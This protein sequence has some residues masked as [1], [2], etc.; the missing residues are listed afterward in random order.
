MDSI[1]ISKE[2]FSALRGLP[3]IQQLIYLT[4]LK[5]YIDYRTGLVGVKRKVS[6]QSLAEELYI[7]PHQGIK[8]GSPSKDQIRRAIK[9]LERSGV[10]TIR[11]MAWQ[12]I[13]Y[14]PLALADYSILNKAAT[15]PPQKVAT[16]R[17]EKILV[18]TE[19]LDVN[20]W[21]GDRVETPKAATPLKE[22][23][24]IYLL[25]QFE[26]FWSRYP[27]KKSKSNALGAFQALHPEPELFKQIMQALDSQIRHR[28]TKEA[29]GLWVPP[30]KFP[31]NWLAQQCWEDELTLD[32]TMEKKH[33]KHRETTGKNSTK[34]MFWIPDDDDAEEPKNNV[35]SFQQRQRNQ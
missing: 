12:L 25:S 29:N 3:Y 13:F 31:A 32:M 14:C 21:K 7:E 8:S 23:N 2:E 22:K 30:W 33:A 20:S 1:K 15:N 18:D 11:S 24:Y 26:K 28:E 16:N 9:G 34:D 19:G 17:G 35:L 5:P 4:G 27:E 6:Y 10:L